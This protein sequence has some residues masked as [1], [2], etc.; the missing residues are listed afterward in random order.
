MLCATI[1]N[2]LGFII[3]VSLT[4]NTHCMTDGLT[5]AWLAPYAPELSLA[6]CANRA[7]NGLPDHA[8][9][10]HLLSVVQAGTND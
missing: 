5:L 6:M 9:V 1:F 3:T 8:V 2:L 7:I 10:R 4:A